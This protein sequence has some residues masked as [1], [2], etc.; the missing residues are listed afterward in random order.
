MEMRRTLLNGAQFFL[1]IDV[2]RSGSHVL[3]SFF[4]ILKIFEPLIDCFGLWRL[5]H[6]CTAQQLAGGTSTASTARRARG[7]RLTRTHG[8]TSGG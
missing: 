6:G 4:V 7:E 5:E 8:R 3:K 1:E 2:Q